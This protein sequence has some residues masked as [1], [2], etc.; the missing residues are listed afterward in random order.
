MD[1]LFS[2]DQNN[3]SERVPES[4]LGEPMTDGQRGELLAIIDELT[5]T[6]TQTTEI[7]HGHREQSRDS[8]GIENA[9][10]HY[11]LAGVSVDLRRDRE[12]RLLNIRRIES[13]G[14]GL[15]KISDLELELRPGI[16]QD[17]YRDKV[18]KYVD[19]AGNPIKVPPK[20]SVAKVALK[21]GKIDEDVLIEEKPD[22]N[23]LTQGDW[24]EAMD[25]LDRIIYGS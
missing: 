2:P 12:I 24:Q 15:S 5:I 22:Q 4:Q 11:Y 16:P 13:I 14:G 9:V 23:I 18:V 1:E 3:E 10:S 25:E 8:T 17:D 21:N 6:P 7:Q 20:V 19:V